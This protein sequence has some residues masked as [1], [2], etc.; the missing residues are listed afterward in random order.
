VDLILAL[1]SA[2]RQRNVMMPKVEVRG[3]TLQYVDFGHGQPVVFVHGGSADLR[4]WDRQ[5][6]FFR[7]RYRAIALSCRGYYPNPALRTDERLPLDV[8]VDD[9]VGFVNALGLPPVHLVGHSS[10]GGFA[11]LLLAVSHAGLLRSLVLIEPPAF[12]LLGVSLPPKLPQILRLL[13]TDPA[14]A[15]GVLKLG[16]A[17]IRPARHAFQAGDDAAG[18]RLFMRANLGDAA[19][20][21]MPPGRFQ[22]ALQNV[23]PLRAQIRSGFPAL[24]DQDV[25]RIRVPTLLASGSNSNAVLQG[26]TRRL[27]ELLSNVERIEIAGAS[28]NMMESHPA[29]FNAGVVAFLDEHH[30]EVSR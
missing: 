15:I 25:R 7:S 29:E 19:F 21:S 6:A 1:S 30:R 9:L 20:E 13:L 18:L 27:A 23:V 10:P 14:V 5:L 8:V 28:H 11:S 2:S 22:Q 3:T 4:S 26:V 12:P 16:F 17:G 24:S